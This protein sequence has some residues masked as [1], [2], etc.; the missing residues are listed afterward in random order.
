MSHRGKP[1]LVATV[2]ELR[3]LCEARMNYWKTPKVRRPYLR[4]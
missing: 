3:S 1:L 4:H 2:G